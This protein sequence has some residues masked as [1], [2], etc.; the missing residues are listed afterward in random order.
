MTLNRICSNFLKQKNLALFDDIKI[1]D[2]WLAA[3]S[4]QNGEQIDDSCMFNEP[5][6]HGFDELCFREWGGVKLSSSH[7]L[8]AT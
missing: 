4:D 3:G 2:I 5:L 6:C 8:Y 7:V 1:S